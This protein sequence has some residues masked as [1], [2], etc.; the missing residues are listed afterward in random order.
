MNS[1]SGLRLWG[2]L[3]VLPNFLKRRRR[4]LMV[5]KWNEHSIIWKQLWWTF[6]Q[7]ACQLYASSK[8]ETSVALCCDKT[9]HFGVAFYCLQHKVHLCTPVRN[10]L[11][12]D[13]L[14]ASH[15]HPGRNQLQLANAHIWWALTDEHLFQLYQADGRQSVWRRVGKG[16]ADVNVVTRE[17]HGGGGVVL[18][19][20]ISYGQR[21]QLH[22][23]DG[24][25]NAQRY[26]TWRDPEAH[27]CAIHPPPSPHVAA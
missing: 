25:L 13:H 19:A 26:S 20:G 8:F 4:R 16:W 2:R 18:W 17:P 5:E 12:E 21:I 3:D 14:C 27:C 11:K 9:A 22:F 15:P 7:S 23:I 10:H 1:G 6:L 24:K